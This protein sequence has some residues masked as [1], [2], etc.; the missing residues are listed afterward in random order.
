MSQQEFSKAYGIPLA[1]L[2][3]WEQGRRKLD[4]TAITYLK[5]IMRF[6]KGI[7]VAQKTN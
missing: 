7:M 5:A 6:P 1:T 2:R 3:N 4:T